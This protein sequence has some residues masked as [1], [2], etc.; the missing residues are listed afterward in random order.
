MRLRFVLMVATLSSG[1]V[2][3]Q[4][5]GADTT[6]KAVDY[7]E[8]GSVVTANVGDQLLAKGTITEER[9]LA[10]TTAIDGA[11]FDIPAGAY[12]QVGF[13]QRND[14]YSASGVVGAPLCDPVSAL[15]VEKIDSAKLCVV[16]VFGG[17]ACYEGI[18]ERKTR[19][20]ERGE[21][22]Q[23]TLI[24]SGRIGDK[25]NIG[26]REFTNNLARPAFNNDVEYDLAASRTIGYKGAQL[27]VI[28][29]NNN[30]ITYRVLKNFP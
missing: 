4:Y 23:Q 19:L 3:V 7:P 28:D 21:S 26:Y 30:S 24:Y 14:F 25:I 8:V 11:C 2:T 12:K 17:K 16:T 29:A 22:F 15:S 27:E 20:S 5:N 13:D 6:V 10:V 1:C 18:F 9:V